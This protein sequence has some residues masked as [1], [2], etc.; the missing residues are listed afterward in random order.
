MKRLQDFALQ[1]E[2]KNRTL[3]V[4][5]TNEFLSNLI[6]AKIMQH[7]QQSAYSKRMFSSGCFASDFDRTGSFEKLHEQRAP[8]GPK[9]ASQICP[10]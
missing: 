6:T 10:R 7:Q 4:S 5:H 8:L 9:T 2:G 3:V 1:D